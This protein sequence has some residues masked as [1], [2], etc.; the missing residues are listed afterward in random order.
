MKTEAN[1]VRLEVLSPLSQIT[2]TA[3]SALGQEIFLGEFDI[4]DP[5]LRHPFVPKLWAIHRINYLLDQMLLEGEILRFVEEIVQLSTGFGLV[6]PYTSILID[7]EEIQEEVSQEEML[8]TDTD[9][10]MAVIPD[11]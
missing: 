11:R 1:P 2:I 4:T 6:T 5:E 8:E 9:S 7:P 10:S 3:E